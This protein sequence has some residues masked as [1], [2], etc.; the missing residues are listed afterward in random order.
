MRYRSHPKRAWVS[1]VRGW[2]GDAD[3]LSGEKHGFQLCL[4]RRRGKVGSIS[5]SEAV[6]SF[7]VH[8]S[9]PVN[10]FSE[11][12]DRRRSIG[13]AP[14]SGSDSDRPLMNSPAPKPK[15][16]VSRDEFRSNPSPP[17]AV[18]PTRN[19]LCRVSEPEQVLRLHLMV[20]AALQKKTSFFCIFLVI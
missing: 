4:P 3:P 11:S 15:I 10:L 6:G 8:R 12:A 2:R 20:V 14:P 13:F 1:G 9:A 18:S 16:R 7:P 19:L 17:S 5:D